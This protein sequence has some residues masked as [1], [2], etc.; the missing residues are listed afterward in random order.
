MILRCIMLQHRPFR[1]SDRKTVKTGPRA[2]RFGQRTT[3]STFGF[4]NF[5]GDVGSV[6]LTKRLFLRDPGSKVS[7]I[8]AIS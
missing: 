4:P 6:F 2:P 3:F 7:D 5:S 1:P 8:F